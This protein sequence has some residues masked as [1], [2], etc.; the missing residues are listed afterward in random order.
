MVIAAR[1][2]GA[3]PGDPRFALRRLVRLVRIGSR[4]IDPNVRQSAAGWRRQA[5][6]RLLLLAGSEATTGCRHLMTTAVADR[7]QAEAGTVAEQ[8]AVL[9]AQEL[10]CDLLTGQLLGR[11]RRG[12]QSCAEPEG[13]DQRGRHE[14]RETPA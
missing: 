9:Q 1:D 5:A 12:A 10:L 13:H 8:A 14:D 6:A 4:V 2:F 11:R 7:L 3:S